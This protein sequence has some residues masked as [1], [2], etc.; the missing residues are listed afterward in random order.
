MSTQTSS[1]AVVSF[2]SEPLIVVDEHDRVL[3]HDSKA[4]LHRGSGKLHQAFSS[5]P[6]GNGPSA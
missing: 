4:A 5:I 3:G 2:D 1:A 6:D